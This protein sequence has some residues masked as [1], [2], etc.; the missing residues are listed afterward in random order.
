MKKVLILTVG[1]SHEPIVKSIKDTKADYVVFLC[2]D[3][4]LTTK[5]SYTQITDK[6]EARDSKDPSKKLSLPNIPTQTNLKEGTWEIQKIK[7]F[8]DLNDCYQISQRIIEEMRQK[9]KPD[10]IIAD[11]TG[12]TKTMT[13][14]LVAAALDDGNCK[15]IL[16]AGI[17][18]NLNKVTDKTEYVKPISHYDTLASKSLS[19]IASLLKRFDFAGAVNILEALIRFPLSNEK[20]QGIKSHLNISKGF[21]AWDRFDH[22]SAFEFLNPFRKYLVSYILPLEK[23]KTDIENKNL[24]YLMVEDLLLN[25]ERRAIQGRYEDAIGRIYRAIELIAQIRLKTLYKQDTGNITIDTLPSLKEEFKANLEKYR[26]NENNEIKIGLRASYD[27]LYELNDFAFQQWYQE[28]KNRLIN[29]LKYRNDS[30]FAHGFKAIDQNTYEREVPI[31][32]KLIR[33]L[34]D[35]IYKDEKRAEISQFP[36][37]LS[38]FPSFT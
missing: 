3:D 7:Y 25:A 13:A 22:V 28:N 18:S 29:F 30:L 5:G 17:R 4:L 37:D 14:G 34:L 15:I 10:E 31:I 23:I 32:I 1:G 21:D 16:V 9:F 26:N 6:V 24:G 36:N 19:Q 12:G 2:S 20:E 8:D 27:L 35:A 38:Q 11:Y 33:K